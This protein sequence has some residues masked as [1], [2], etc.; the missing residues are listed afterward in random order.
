MAS[1]EQV[2]KAL[3]L[4]NDILT[5][6]QTAEPETF[7]NN[8]NKILTAMFNKVYS[9]IV[10]IM[11]SDN[12]FSKYYGA[13]I[14]YG[15]TLEN[16]WIELPEGYNFYDNPNSIDEGGSPFKKANPSIKTLYATINFTMQYKTTITD[17]EFRKAVWS[18]TGFED[19]VNKIISSLPISATLDRYFATIGML[20]NA[21]I[22]A[23]GIQDVEY[24]TGNEGKV[25]T[26]TIVDYGTNMTFPNTK[27]NKLAVMNRTPKDRLL[28]VIKQSILNK[29]NLDFLSGVFNLSKVDLISMIIPIETFSVKYKNA[30]GEVVETADN[31]DFAILDTKGLDIHNSLTSSGLLY[32]PEELYTNHYYNV[33]D[34]IS[35]K[36]FYNAR[37]FK[38]KLKS[39]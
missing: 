7:P 11:D 1:N 38:L 4:P 3:S 28:L 35:Y 10:D 18:A 24:T 12:P 21:N 14:N 6:L 29:I 20:G 17:V 22:Y 31:I 19:L 26:Q 32:N 34:I 36:Y 16:V 33:W 8:K 13:P 23:N 2:L 39:E 27:N 5:Q 9:I 30:G 25:A 37:A 15:D